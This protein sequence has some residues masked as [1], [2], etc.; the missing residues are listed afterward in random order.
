MVKKVK[1]FFRKKK[2]FK[3]AYALAGQALRL[4]L[5]YENDLKKRDN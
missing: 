4:F 2:E 1:D 3:E 5:S